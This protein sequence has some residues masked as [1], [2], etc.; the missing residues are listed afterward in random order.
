[1]VGN[2]AHK[3]TAITTIN[4]K[5]SKTVHACQSSECSHSVGFSSSRTRTSILFESTQYESFHLL[6]DLF[7]LTPSF[8]I[9]LSLTFSFAFIVLLFLLVSFRQLSCLKLM[10]K[11]CDM[12]QAEPTLYSAPIPHLDSLIRNF[13]AVCFIIRCHFVFFIHLYE[14][15]VQQRLT[16]WISNR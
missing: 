5:R 13:D 6:C 16:N 1:L 8:K 15:F 3:Q 10:S 11:I 14:N 7:W 2:V 12:V 4:R 9:L